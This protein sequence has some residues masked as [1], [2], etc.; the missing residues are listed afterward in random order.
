MNELRDL[1]RL[2]SMREHGVFSRI[3]KSSWQD[4]LIRIP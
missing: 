1:A 4:I 2:P 3:D